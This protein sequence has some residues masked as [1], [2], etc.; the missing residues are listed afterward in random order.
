MRIWNQ[1]EIRK[2]C[3]AALVMSGILL[4][5]FASCKP[6]KENKGKTISA[7]QILGDSSYRAICYGGYREKSRSVQPTKDE[8]MDDMRILFAMGIRIVRTYNVHL[9]QAENLLHAIQELREEDPNFEMYVMLGAWIDCRN[10][11]SPLP[12]DHSEESINNAIEI[13]KAVELANEFPDI[14]KILAVGNEAMVKWAT[15]YYVQPWVILKWVKY[16]QYLK[17]VDKL[18]KGLWITSSDNFASWGGGDPA[19]HVPDLVELI[20]AVDYVSVHTYPMH[21]THYNPNFW[22]I[23]PSEVELPNS[24]KVH[25]A[26]SRSRDYA[27][28]QYKGVVN[29]IKS[30]G[31]DKPVHI[32]ETGWATVSNR[33]YGS[34]GSKATGEYKSA[35]Y[36]D[37]MRE[38]SEENGVSCFYF[39][40][41]DEQW[42]D[43]NNPEGSE[44]H[45]GLI[46]LQA[47]AKYVLWEEV[48]RGTFEGLS[49]DGRPITKTYGG[50]E[51][52][53]KGDVE[54]PPVVEH[55][56]IFSQ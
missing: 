43:A 33:Q 52:K 39:E 15:S 30:L 3:I 21:D 51:R 54:L 1:G 37:L 31:I 28:N 35:L 50:N 24:E 56:Q 22:G 4:L 13:H 12:P 20:K 2:S 34:E 8:I 41:F 44:N 7:A 46:N 42:K 25:R 14:V 26:M 16:L 10:A 18:P 55:L 5:V 48:D 23:F 45:F 32:G 9:E 11:W 38:W 19:Y 27:I 53:L 6:M 36:H 17:S 40:A 49:R 47:E 29:Y